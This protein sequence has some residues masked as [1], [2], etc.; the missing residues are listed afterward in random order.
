M[1]YFILTDVDCQQPSQM[2]NGKVIL[3]TNATYYGAAV[4]YEC[5]ENYKL[6]GV[7]RRLCLEDGTWGYETPVC[8][9]ITC[10]VLVSN[11]TESIIIDSGSGIIGGQAQ[12]TCPKG[13]YLIGNNSRVCLQNG[14]WDG[15]PP[16]C[17]S[18]DCDQPDT[19]ENGRVI[20]V[21]GSTLY[22]GSAEY[23]CIPNFNRIGPYLRK[24]LEDGKW[25]GE[26]PRCE[27]LYKYK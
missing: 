19:I 8:K 11:D 4:L 2:E 9:E 1:F 12:Y 13:K 3:A 24:C 25:S 17:K 20:V 26:E 21:N 16:K 14:Q 7:S 10:N 5:N 22:G 6:D 23:H 27:G 18:I 15:K